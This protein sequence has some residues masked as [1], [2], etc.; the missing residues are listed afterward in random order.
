M[1]DAGSTIRTFLEATAAK[2]P[3]PGGGAVA[4][5]AGALAAATGEM[6]LNYSIGKKS[7]VEYEVQLRAAV[8]ELT[9]TRRIMLELMVEDQLAYDAMTKAQKLPQ[10]A[11][12]R[13]GVVDAALLAAIR[14][15]QAISAT[16]VAILEICNRIAGCANVHL[17]SD[18]AV[19]ADLAM[20]TVRCATHSARVN[21]RAVR[22]EADRQSLEATNSRMLAHGIKVVQNVQ[23]VIASRTAQ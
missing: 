12:D 4:A 22:K 13:N 19:C 9:R 14:V 3:A 20:A 11:P 7:L 23:Q 15:P 16:G 10:D 8:A 6:V 5:L 2:Q 17:L 18:L 1:E 21:L